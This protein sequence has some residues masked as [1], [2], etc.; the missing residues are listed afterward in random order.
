MVR[1]LLH[2]LLLQ[3]SCH[4]KV[5]RLLPLDSKATTSSVTREDL[6]KTELQTQAHTAEDHL[7][8]LMS[9]LL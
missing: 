3:R 7:L 4:E 2:T 5:L 1:L 9:L 8:K 6:K